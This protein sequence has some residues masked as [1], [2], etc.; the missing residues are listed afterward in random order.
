MNE[1]QQK[2]IDYI[3]K[4]GPISLASFMQISSFDAQGYYRQQVPIGPGEDF[5]TAPEISQIFNEI[6]AFWLM[7]CWEQIGQPSTCCLLELGAGRGTLLKDIWRVAKLRPSFKQ[8][9]EIHIIE[10]NYRLRNIQQQSL[11]GLPV[12]WHTHLPNLQ[13]KPILVIANEFF[14]VFPIHQFKKMPEGWMERMVSL[15]D[16]GKLSWQFIQSEK[17]R[18]LP[19]KGY[20]LGT[21]FEYSAAATS[22]M[23]LLAR[24]V[25]DNNGVI[26]VIDYG[27]NGAVGESFQAIK[28]HQ[29]VDPLQL[30]GECDTTAWV[31]FAA[32]A[33]EAIQQ[34]MLVWGPIKQS[35]WLERMGFNLR[36]TNL[37]KKA[38]LQE[39]EMLKRAADRLLSPKQMGEIF[40]V[41]TFSQYSGFYPA[42]FTKEERNV[43][44]K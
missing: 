30:V 37:L 14:D 17:S 11:Q 5:I 38:D 25:G 9:M 27:R 34:N 42:G 7:D 13:G 20:S 26:L 29:P 43:N 22:Y 3:R 15:N 16:Q 19:A 4:E 24:L 39:A 10:T 41:A 6:I 36:M 44:S 28:H 18:M 33:Y 31:D 12:S 35:V 32:L 8:S 23:K 21:V 1:L 40:K 2:I